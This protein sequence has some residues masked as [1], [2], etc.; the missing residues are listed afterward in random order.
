MR[1]VRN[2]LEVITPSSA[3]LAKSLADLPGPASSAIV[4]IET[5][6]EFFHSKIWIT[7]RNLRIVSNHPLWGFTA[8]WYLFTS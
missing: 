6:L 8:L 2:H 3:I 7:G 4:T 5:D 1:I